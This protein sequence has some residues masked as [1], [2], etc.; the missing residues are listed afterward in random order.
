MYNSWGWE[1]HGVARVDGMY[2]SGRMVG[3]G[4][5]LATSDATQVGMSE[6]GVGD[7]F[8]QAV[9]LDTRGLREKGRDRHWVGEQGCYPSTKVA[10]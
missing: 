2:V 7:S 9:R 6:H 1:D 4:S 5:G 8:Y 3:K 10:V